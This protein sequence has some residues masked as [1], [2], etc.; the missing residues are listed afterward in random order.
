MREAL[1]NMME[2]GDYSVRAERRP[3]NEVGVTAVTIRADISPELLDEAVYVLMH[4][5]H[6]H[7][8]EPWV[9]SFRV[10]DFVLYASAYDDHDLALHM[11]KKHIDILERRLDPEDMERVRVTS[12]V[13]GEEFMTADGVEAVLYG[14]IRR[15]LKSL[16]RGVT[17]T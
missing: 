6:A 15:V 13:D 17:I 2:M 12:C 1:V 3:T 4:H 8:F 11:W 9:G 7:P 10:M 5:L 14:T 16:Q